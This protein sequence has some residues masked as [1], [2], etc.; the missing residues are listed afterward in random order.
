VLLIGSLV[1]AMALIV[2][3]GRLALARA[4][5]S[6]LG[7]SGRLH[8]R[9]VWLFSLIA[10]IPTLLVV[11]FASLLFQSGVEFWFSNDSRGMLENASSLANGYY[12]DKLRDVGRESVAMAGDIR[13]YFD[14]APITS[15]D[16]SRAIPGRSTAARWTRA[17]L[18][19][20][21]RW[22][23]AH[24]RHRRSQWQGQ[25]RADH[26]RRVAQA[27]CRRAGRRQASAERIEAVTSIDHQRGIYLYVARNSDKLALSQF[28]RAKSVL[29]PMTCSRAVR[30]RSSC[31][32]TSRCS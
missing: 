22:H 8:V 10:A 32:S 28:E 1:P 12:A 13:G 6:G 24:G 17:R 21:P 9:L 30:A 27:R 19:N 26:A 15:Q 14:Q 29:R 7:T 16:F 5:R 3:G 18:S 20:A 31:V 2:L 11:I 23:L 4:A 25:P